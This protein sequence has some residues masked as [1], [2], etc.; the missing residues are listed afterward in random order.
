[1]TKYYFKKNSVQEIPYNQHSMYKNSGLRKSHK[2]KTAG[3]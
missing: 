3:W 1:M 2:L